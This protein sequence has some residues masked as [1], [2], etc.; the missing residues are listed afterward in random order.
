MHSDK[1]AVF[2][3]ITPYYARGVT[4]LDAAKDFGGAVPYLMLSL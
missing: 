3:A 1:L 2:K 4:A